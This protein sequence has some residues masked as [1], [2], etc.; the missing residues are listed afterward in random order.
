M[1]SDKCNLIMAKATGV[2]VSLFNIGTCAFWHTTV[3]TMHS[4]CA[5][6][7]PA[8]VPFILLTAKDVDLAVAHDGF[9]S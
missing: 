9:P 7:C 3:C 5:Y 1:P 6:Q 4:L 8:C 2:N